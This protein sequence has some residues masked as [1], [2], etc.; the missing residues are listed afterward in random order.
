MSE[1]LV[2]QAYCFDKCKHCVYVSGLGQFL[3]AKI[4]AT[5]L[6]KQSDLSP[7]YGVCMSLCVCL[8]VDRLIFYAR[9]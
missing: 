2:R 3:E 8:L 7:H 4:E 5:P 1:R 9:N 6:L